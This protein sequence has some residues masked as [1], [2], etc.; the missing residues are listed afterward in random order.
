M[1]IILWLTF[2]LILSPKMLY[3]FSFLSA[4]QPLRNH[5]ELSSELF[6]ENSLHHD[7]FPPVHRSLFNFFPLEFPSA[8]KGYF[9]FGIDVVC[10][11]SSQTFQVF[12][13]VSVLSSPPRLASPS[14]HNTSPACRPPY[15]VFYLYLP[16]SSSNNLK[17]TTTAAVA[18]PP[19][20]LLFLHFHPYFSQALSTPR[21]YS[22]VPTTD[23]YRPLPSLPAAQESPNPSRASDDNHNQRQSLTGSALLGNSRGT[24]FRG[25]HRRPPCL[26]KR[27]T[28][29]KKNGAMPS[30]R[31][32]LMLLNR[33]GSDITPPKTVP[34]NL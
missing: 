2:L 10:S 22:S 4:C 32:L 25:C 16:V 13:S 9:L 29:K 7:R 15:V 31:W 8:L 12:S 18:S 24:K 20:P 23:S 19:P 21:P 27:R 34:I 11:L 1:L 30:R 26:I 3:A 28:Q 6:A 5:S 14:S 33:K 17:T